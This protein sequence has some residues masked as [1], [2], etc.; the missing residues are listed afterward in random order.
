MRYQ[1]LSG[2]YKVC[3]AL[4]AITDC[5]TDFFGRSKTLSEQL[6]HS[7][8]PNTGNAPNVDPNYGYGGP[9]SRHTSVLP[10]YAQVPPHYAHEGKP[11]SLTEAD[12]NMIGGYGHATPQA[13]SPEMRSSETFGGFSY[14]DSRPSMQNIHSR[15]LIKILTMKP[16]TDMM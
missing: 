5:S 14:P 1:R 12:G 2:R 16:P 11:P 6:R 10:P 3:L 9:N 13:F 15:Y 4:R 7:R 8:T